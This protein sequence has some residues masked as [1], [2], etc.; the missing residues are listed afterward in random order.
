MKR[1][2][3]LIPSSREHHHALSLSNHIHHQPNDDHYAVIMAQRDELLNH[4]KEEEQQFAT[5]WK[6]LN[7]PNL[8]EYSLVE[9]HQLRQFLQRSFQA[10]TLAEVLT[11]H[12]RF[13]EHEQFLAI[14]RIL[15]QSNGI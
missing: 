3:T 13:K 4:F 9:Y 2:P 14:K 8:H 5:C 1:Y 6:Q 15:I 11:N 10:A 7:N 12:I